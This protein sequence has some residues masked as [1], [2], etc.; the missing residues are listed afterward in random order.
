MNKEKIFKNHRAE[1]YFTFVKEGIKTVEGRLNKGKYK[2]I[3]PKDHIV[4][5]SNDETKSFEVVVIGVRNYFSFKELLEKEGLKKVLP[6][7]E[8]LEDGSNIYREF[9]SEEDER[10][11][12]V[13]A[14]EVEVVK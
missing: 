5:F 7:V 9:Y 11:F 4:V 10:N 3:Q 6:N 1:P 8:T 12:G 14:I 13:V 2:E